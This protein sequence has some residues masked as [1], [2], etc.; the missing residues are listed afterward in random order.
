VFAPVFEPRWFLSFSQSHKLFVTSFDGATPCIFLPLRGCHFLPVRVEIGV[1]L[2][3]MSP[4][5]Y[6]TERVVPEKMEM[7]IRKVRCRV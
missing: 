2:I 1:R 4:G 6:F 3:F 7:K 5:V